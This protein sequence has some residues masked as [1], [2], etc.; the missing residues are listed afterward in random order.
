MQ[1]WIHPRSPVAAAADVVFHIRPACWQRAWH[2]LLSCFLPLLLPLSPPLPFSL[3]FS[4]LSL[5]CPPYTNTHLLLLLPLISLSGAV[6]SP[7]CPE[8]K[9]KKKKKKSAPVW[10]HHCCHSCSANMFETMSGNNCAQLLWMRECCQIRVSNSPPVSQYESPAARCCTGSGSDNG[11]VQTREQE[12]PH[13]LAKHC[14]NTLSDDIHYWHP[15]WMY[16]YYRY[17]SAA[18]VM[19]VK[20]RKWTIIY[21]YNT[22]KERQRLDS[23]KWRF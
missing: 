13:T 5:T 18:L 14:C 17:D 8:L 21:Y 19:I 15:K 23:L 10:W 9:K 6:I 2:P 4:P 12:H 1:S 3:C 11:F 16:N 22:T 7:V 20:L